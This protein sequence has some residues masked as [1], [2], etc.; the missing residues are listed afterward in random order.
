MLLGI[1]PALRETLSK[2]SNTA[3]IAACA[4][5]PD[6]GDS[7]VFTLRLLARRIQ[8]LTA[9]VKELTRRVTKAVRHDHP[10]LLDIT[11]VGPD[12][13]AALLVA[14]RRQPGTAGQ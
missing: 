11:G 10:Q 14:G 13:A 12:S 7:A 4:D 2:L 9:E 1:D 5:L 8:Q 6:A 3:L